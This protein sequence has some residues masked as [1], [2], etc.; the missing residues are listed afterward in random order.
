[1][2]DDITNK[3]LLE[4]MLA[5]KNYLQTQITDVKKQITDVKKQVTDVKTGVHGL[6]E[7]MHQGFTE[8]QE[9][10]QALQEDL[11]ATMRMQAKH[12]E[13]LERISVS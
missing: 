1:M 12:Q 5:M 13:K 11:E 9:H 2:A 8:A 7:E 10:R 6:R 4:H 3:M